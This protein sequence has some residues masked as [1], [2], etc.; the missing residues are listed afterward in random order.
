MEI[1]IVQAA[2]VIQ[3]AQRD[4]ALAV[5]EDLRLVVRGNN[6]AMLVLTKSQLNSKER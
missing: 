2:Q 6:R 5:P 1:K 3:L 4:P